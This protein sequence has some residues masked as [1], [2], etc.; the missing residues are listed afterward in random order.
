MRVWAKDTLFKGQA[1]QAYFFPKVNLKAV[2]SGAHK[3]KRTALPFRFRWLNQ[4]H[5]LARYELYECYKALPI[6]KLSAVPGS[7]Q[8][9]I[10]EEVNPG[11]LTFPLTKR[12]IAPARHLASWQCESAAQ[13]TTDCK[14]T[15]GVWTA[16]VRT[17]MSGR[18]AASAAE[19]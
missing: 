12:H 3:I 9:A 11:I 5:H 2:Q 1:V 10:L 15:K 18:A 19:C 4:R 16:E 14:Q 8:C 17:L 7:K 6:T 13:R